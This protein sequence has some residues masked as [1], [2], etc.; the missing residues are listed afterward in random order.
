MENETDDGGT[1][2]P[3]SSNDEGTQGHRPQGDLISL[4]LFFYFLTK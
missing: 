3:L 1:G 4:F 2:G